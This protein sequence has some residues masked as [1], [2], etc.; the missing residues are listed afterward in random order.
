ML[1]PPD[2]LS[3]R[4][5]KYYACLISATG[6]SATMLLRVLAA[7]LYGLSSL[8]LLRYWCSGMR[9]LGTVAAEDALYYL[10]TTGLTGLGNI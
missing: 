3:V 4:A 7:M 10:L 8:R 2:V 1:A 9:D 5:G 6:V